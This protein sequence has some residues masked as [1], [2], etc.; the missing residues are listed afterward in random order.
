MNP[1][2]L[3]Q[4]IA[5]TSRHWEFLNMD[6]WTKFICRQCKEKQLTITYTLQTCILASGETSYDMIRDYDAWCIKC[7]QG[8]SVINDDDPISEDYYVVDYSS[9]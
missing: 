2:S 6:D 5:D 3:S 9:D 4:V 1:F 8:I 7:Q